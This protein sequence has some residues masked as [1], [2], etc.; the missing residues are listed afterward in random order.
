MMART[1]RKTKTSVG[2]TSSHSARKKVAS[3]KHKAHS[4]THG[5]RSEKFSFKRMLTAEGWRRLVMKKKHK[6]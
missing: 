2:R 5:H 6:K 3:R 4:K 1:T